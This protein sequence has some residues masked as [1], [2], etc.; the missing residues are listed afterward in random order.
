VTSHHPDCWVVRW[1]LDRPASLV[2]PT[3]VLERV[4]G[5]D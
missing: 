1:V 4:A 2:P 5:P 3:A